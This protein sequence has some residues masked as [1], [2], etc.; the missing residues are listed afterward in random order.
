MKKY[1]FSFICSIVTIPVTAQ[2]G[3]VKENY[4]KMDIGLPYL[5]NLS[6]C[7]PPCTYTVDNYFLFL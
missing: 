5:S 7:Y 6:T 3:F 2:T 1:F 4:T